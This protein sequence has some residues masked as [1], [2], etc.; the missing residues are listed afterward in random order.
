MLVVLGALATR[1][2]VHRRDWVLA[3]MGVVTFAVWLLAIPDSEWQSI[4]WVVDNPG[5]TA[6][7]GILFGAFAELLAPDGP[8]SS[9]WGPAPWRDRTSSPR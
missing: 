4:D 1:K 2:A 5:W 3:G 9:P 7:G 8:R 6:K